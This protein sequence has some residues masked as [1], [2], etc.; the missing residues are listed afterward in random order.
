MRVTFD[1]NAWQPAVRPD[2]FPADPRSADFHKI[3][4]ALKSGAIEG[5]ISETCGT[6]EAIGKAARAQHFAG[7]KAKTTMTTTPEPGGVIKMSLTVS[8][9]HSQH[10][11]LHPIMADRIRDALA[12]D[13]R[14][15]SAPRIGMPRPQEFLDASGGP[16]PTKYAQWPDLGA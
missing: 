7:Q 6:L 12:L 5:F 13:V 3:N 2:K 4:A 9:D 10:P 16:D 1:S 8:P 15:L 11:G 14:L